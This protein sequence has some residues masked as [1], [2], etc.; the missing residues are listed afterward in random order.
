[1]IEANELTIERLE[2]LSKLI[3]D[4]WDLETLIQFAE[5]AV[6]QDYQYDID[7]ATR[8]ANDYDITLEDLENE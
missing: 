7:Q 3:V 6:F 5:V 2:V 4:K 8:D 1:M